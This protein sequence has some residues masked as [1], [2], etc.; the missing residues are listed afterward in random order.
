MSV[1]Y[2]SASKLICTPFLVRATVEL[3]TPKPADCVLLTNL[4]FANTSAVVQR[5]DV[6]D[7]TRAVLISTTNKVHATT[8]SH[9]LSL[10]PDS[11]GYFT[12][13]LHPPSLDVENHTA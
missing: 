9:A 12:L 10:P 1:I 8:L 6:L 5:L 2:R 13:P 7:S 3:V 4:L 11:L